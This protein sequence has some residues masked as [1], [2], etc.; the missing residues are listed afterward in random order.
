MKT[1]KW[2]A[3][4][5]QAPKDECWIW[6]GA[7]DSH[8]YSLIGSGQRLHR[9]MYRLLRGA[10]PFNRI[11]HHTCENTGCINPH[12]LDAMTQVEHSVIHKLTELATTSRKLKTHC[13]WGHPLSGNNL[14]LFRGRRHCKACRSAMHRK[15]RLAA[16]SNARLAA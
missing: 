9:I 13:K 16:R 2:D 6:D 5:L 12:H 10:V 1:W 8:G 7:H 3:A 11:L 4:T 14:Y 15:R